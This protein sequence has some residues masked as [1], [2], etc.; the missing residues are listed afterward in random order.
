MPQKAMG[1]SISCRH[2]E[3]DT[4][5]GRLKAISEIR[6]DSEAVDVTCLDAENGYRQYVQ[7]LR[8]MGEVTLEGFYEA[9]EAGQQKLREL[10]EEGIV[11]PFTV[12]FPDESAVQFSA[13]VKSHAM[14][15]AQVDGAVG[16][17]AV[18]RLTGGVTLL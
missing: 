12:T 8:D 11:V 17:S 3:K 18:L 5:I 7:G 10:Y 1:T 16:F 4:V 15:A 14:G 13:F 6:A 9:G 2:Q